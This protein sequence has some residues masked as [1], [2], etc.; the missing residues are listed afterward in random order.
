MAIETIL[1][2]HESRPCRDCGNLLAIID[3]ARCRVNR[4]AIDPVEREDDERN[5][6]LAQVALESH[7]EEHESVRVDR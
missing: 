6:A 2:P 1:I 5:L 3:E 4:R 7:L